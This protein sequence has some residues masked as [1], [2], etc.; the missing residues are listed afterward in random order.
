[1]KISLANQIKLRISICILL[2]IIGIPYW[3]YTGGTLL[4]LIA[5]RLFAMFIHTVGSIGSHRWL[6]HNSFKPSSFGARFM[7]ASIVMNGL[8]KPL[9]YAITHLEHHRHVDTELD[10]HTPV[11]Y[12]FWDMF[13]GRYGTKL[14]TGYIVPKHF[15]RN[16]EAMFVHNHFWKLVISFNVLLAIIDLP[17]ALLFTPVNFLGAW[18]GANIVNYHGHNGHKG[19][20]Q[21]EPI[22]MA[23]WWAFLISFSGEENHKNHH[24]AP[25]CYH[26]EGNGRKDPARWIVEYIL[27]D[28]DRLKVA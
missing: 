9:F 25:S 7:L 11:V 12:S 8:Q 28:K 27:M 2:V 24:D 10:P 14:K 16:K 23:H 19:R 26:F 4:G 5:L 17:T 18:I 1:M 20:E 3:F 22:N 6:A 21:I 13:W 15:L